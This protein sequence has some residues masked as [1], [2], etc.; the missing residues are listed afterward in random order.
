MSKNLAELPKEEMDK[1]N[2]DKAAGAGIAEREQL[3]HL[4]AYFRGF[5]A[6]YK[7]K[8]DSLDKIDIQPK[9]VRK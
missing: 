9:E 3:E 8:R 4:R 2:V 1:I 7:S 5:L 6:N